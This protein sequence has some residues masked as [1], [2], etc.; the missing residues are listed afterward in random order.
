MRVY[1]GDLEGVRMRTVSL[2]AVALLVAVALTS[3]AGCGTS[4]GGGGRLEG[5]RW[6]LES[7]DSGGRA[8]G[9]PSG[10]EVDA[11]FENGRVSG[12]SG[13]NTYSGEY[14][15]SGSRLTISKL[16]STLMAG[17][18]ELMDLEQAYL[19]LLEQTASYTA[20]DGG[21]TLF[22]KNGDVLLE[23]SKGKAASLTGGTW[24]V[25]SYYNG[26]DA[27]TSVINGTALTS[28]FGKD[29]AVTGSGGV[30]TYRASYSTSGKKITIGT[31][32][33]TLMAATDPAVSQQETEFLAALELAVEFEVTGSSLKLLRE[34]GTIAVTY[35]LAE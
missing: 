4:T 9:V 33:T 7:Y 20:E 13:V 34:G 28:V 24:N 6:A 12:S 25:I 14:V 16:A 1:L 23:Y 21:L 10:S 22:G 11:T 3:G 29:G 30:N 15:L 19:G 8:V 18:Q 32:T 35:E 17:P 26:R 27:L 31:P 5:T 2:T